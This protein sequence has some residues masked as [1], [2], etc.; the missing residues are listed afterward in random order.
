MRIFIDFS[1]LSLETENRKSTA[2]ASLSV[3]YISRV[4]MI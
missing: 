2:P 4:L 1:S 3:I